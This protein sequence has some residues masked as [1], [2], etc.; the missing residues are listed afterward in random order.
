MFYYQAAIHLQLLVSVSSLLWFAAPSS[1]VIQLSLYA[2]HT[3]RN[4]W[5]TKLSSI[6]PIARNT[7]TFW[8]SEPCIQYV[9]TLHFSFMF[10][11]LQFSTVCCDSPSFK[12]WFRHKNHLVSVMKRSHFGIK[13]HKHRW[14]MSPQWLKFNLSFAKGGNKWSWTVVSHLAAT[15]LV[16]R[17]SH[18]HLLLRESADLHVIWV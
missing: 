3:T 8:V 2:P 9:E 12:V 14:K 5:E 6:N 16:S 7:L 18:P 15:S 11:M 4:G 1:W 10:F 13:C 17:R